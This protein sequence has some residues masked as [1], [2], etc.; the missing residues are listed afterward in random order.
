VVIEPGG[1]IDCIVYCND[2]LQFWVVVLLQHSA[3]ISGA[4]DCHAVTANP[5]RCAS[6]SSVQNRYGCTGFLAAKVDVPSRRWQQRKINTF[7]LQL[8]LHRGW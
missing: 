1:E 5:K 6:M 3:I 7:G 8:S 4:V 2:S